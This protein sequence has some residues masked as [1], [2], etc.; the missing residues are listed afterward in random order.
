MTEDN[1]AESITF[2][3]FRADNRELFLVMLSTLTVITLFKTFFMFG[4]R[5]FP[6]V[7]PD[8]IVIA[9][10]PAVLITLIYHFIWRN[11]PLQK[12]ELDGRERVV[13]LK[14]KRLA[15]DGLKKVAVR[16]FGRFIRVKITPQKGWPVVAILSP[17]NNNRI[18]RELEKI[19]D[20]FQIKKKVETSISKYF[21]SMCS[22]AF[23]LFGLSHE[24]YYYSI[25]AK[26]PLIEL[27]PQEISWTVGPGKKGEWTSHSFKNVNFLI[28]PGYR[29]K[30][31]DSGQ[32]FL[33]KNPEAKTNILVGRSIYES[34]QE[35]M[36]ASYKTRYVFTLLG[37][38]NSM[39]YFEWIYN[40]RVG[41]L[42]ITFK[43]VELDAFDTFKAEKFRHNNFYGL[44]KRYSKNGR[45]TVEVTLVDML[46]GE[47]IAFSF[48]GKE[49]VDENDVRGVID[50][51]VGGAG[52][53]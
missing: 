3:E 33:F 2:E 41:A 36:L 27:K 46:L 49:S 20:N 7:I 11:K 31:F 32:S 5:S 21:L 17:G 4:F 16:D 43:Y 45:T 25:K 34:F 39:D 26:A 40:T 8:F 30:E 10:L 12:L 44:I 35:M 38:S 19:S 13:S 42:P 29:P 47:E 28:P 48:L 52:T 53:T 37:I 22:C 50:S 51:V 9:L 1:T 23:L 6:L 18:S 14:G 15:Y 24:Y